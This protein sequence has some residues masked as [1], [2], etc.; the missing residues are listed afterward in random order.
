V[1]AYGFE[2]AGGAT[3]VDVSG[4]GNHG[5]I[6]GATRT[7]SGRFG[8]AA[9]FD[10]SGD[11]ITVPDAN[12]L[13]LTAAMTLEAWVWPTSDTFRRRP[14]VGKER[15][16]RVAY[17]LSGATATIDA[18]TASVYTGG[19]NVAAGT[20][21]LTAGVWTH[22]AATYDGTR[23]RLYVNG[24][25]VDEDVA[26]GNIATSSR[27][28]RI[29]HNEIDGGIFDGRIDEVR[30]YSRALGAAEIQADMARPVP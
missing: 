15:P 3:A 21:R 24:V 8:A 11:W 27:P 7:P 1:A 23:L 28:L 6:T 30:V 20:G 22:L 25:L 13:D 5:S 19:N 17:F 4:F 26:F 12:S 18:P 2:E 16:G 14:I 9:F 29:G 10:G